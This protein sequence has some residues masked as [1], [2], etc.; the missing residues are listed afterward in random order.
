M[1]LKTHHFT[2]SLMILLL[3]CQAVDAQWEYR[4][5][6]QG[7]LQ[8]IQD[9]SM[10]VRYRESL[11]QFSFLATD[12][13]VQELVLIENT[14]GCQQPHILLLDGYRYTLPPGF[15]LTMHADSHQITG[16]GILGSCKTT[17]GLPISSS[18][19]VLMIDGQF[20]EYQY[21]QRIRIFHRYGETY[22]SYESANGDVVCSNG[23]LQPNLFDPI[24][25]STFE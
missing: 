21:N 25:L 1:S 7:S 24:Y 8:Q 18:D 12:M 19:P 10:P 17:S 16:T 4:V 9:L 5:Y 11:C 6:D 23:T 14:Q 2:I 15:T 3:T 20:I 22:F 13:G